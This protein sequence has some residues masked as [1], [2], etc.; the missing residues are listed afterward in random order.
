MQEAE[1]H[2]R[3][4][5]G[6]IGD[7]IGGAL[8]IGL[9]AAAAGIA[10]A[11][12]FVANG[13]ADAR[14]AAQVMAQTEAV[15]KSTGEAAGFTA[16]E[17][18]NM[19]AELSAASGKSLFGD[20]DIQKGQNLLLTF[21]NIKETLP[22]ATQTMVDMAQALGTDVAGGAVQLGKAL[23]D[24]ING[25]SALSRVGVTF[26]EEQKEQIRVMQEAGDMA[27]AQQVILAELNKEFGG[28]AEAAAKAD[29]GWAQFHDR[30]GELGE[31][32]GTALLPLINELAGFLND[33]VVPIL[34]ES[35]IPVMTDL[36]ANAVPFLTEAWASLQGALGSAFEVL[37]PLIA[38]FEDA[39]DPITGLLDA[40]SEVSPAFELLR[41]VVEAALPPIQSIVE[42]VFGIISGVMS[43]HGETMLADV[44]ET[45]AGIQAV[46]DGIL[47]PIQSIVETVFGA[48]AAFLDTHGDEIESF[49]ATSWDQIAEIIET[50]VAI[51]NAVIVPAFETIAGFLHTHSDDI[52]HIL[53]SAW[54]T[55]SG[56]ITGAL[57]LIQGLLNTVMLA[58]QGDWSGAWASLQETSAQFVSDIMG[59][60]SS[61]LDTIAGFFG[62]SLDELAELWSSNW[63]KLG[64]LA[65]TAVDGLIELIMGMPGQVVGVG[66][67]I[68]QEIWDGIKA[69]WDELVDW[70]TGKM[71]E[72]RDMM[73]F[74][75]PK[76]PESPLYG[77]SK[78]GRAIII[79]ILEGLESVGDLLPGALAEIFSQMT[80]DAK[81]A[82][83]ELGEEQGEAYLR[84]FEAFMRD[85]EALAGDMGDR[86]ADALNDA[87]GGQ[88]DL[89]RA[90][91]R[92]LA[93][94]QD[95]Q[96]SMQE[97]LAED[98][99]DF[100]RMSI[101]MISG[102]VEDQLRTAK[103]EADELAMTDPEKA[104]EF[105][106]MRQK[107]I[108]E[109]AKLQQQFVL[110]N[111]QE[112]R[113]RLVE[114]MR[115]LEQAAQREQDL[116]ERE[117]APGQDQS[118]LADLRAQIQALLDHI[119]RSDRTSE[120]ASAVIDMLNS[121]LARLT[122]I[123]S[124]AGG[125]G[126]WR[127]GWTMVGEQGPELLNL[128]RGAQVLPTPALGAL[129]GGG[130]AGA[131]SLQIGIDA[132][133][134]T[135]GLGWLEQLIDFRIDKK[136][137]RDASAADG[138]RRNR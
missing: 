72:L 59:V 18:A 128:P 122:E 51:I 39:P 33:T 64:Q 61:F 85:A 83:E 138:R 47:P 53:G 91:E 81:A 130:A 134:N 49:I 29:G 118:S 88:I 100:Q 98:L 15:I 54:E 63:A 32:V 108:L 102:S 136:T 38:I 115:L 103:E 30:M 96:Q 89:G 71:Q 120:G 10:A 35:V 14:A 22:D 48:I 86:I 28:S 45:W 65:Q 46:I 73:P 92:A 68:V 112:E 13:I 101:Q 60:V 117:H 75:E 57:N 4:G 56:I 79:N 21:T 111:D 9:A 41:G 137:S 58:I 67:A 2:A 27:G 123:G 116:F 37:E 126:F 11:G 19:A 34:E 77:L 8:K 84:E 7:V 106:Q 1:E 62:T 50:A 94:L 66:Q 55:I 104:A 124:L 17:V 82:A 23:N 40:L 114:R 107:Q 80:D 109:L 93:Q 76:D 69:K 131:M 20:D 119:Q 90:E 12:V 132:S 31:T 24:P 127:G 133:L 125:T 52:Q 16:E 110:S 44:T 87:I 121:L 70:F 6:A 74:S 5:F 36:A 95:F 43:E 42:S 99:T 97:A 25:I 113:D 129:M 78:S 135:R 3:S 105:F 26:T